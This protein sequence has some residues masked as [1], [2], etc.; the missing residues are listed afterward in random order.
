MDF[1]KKILRCAAAHLSQDE[2][3]ESLAVSDKFLPGSEIGKISREGDSWLAEVFVPKTASPPFPPNDHVNDAENPKPPPSDEED[4]KTDSDPD[5][6][7][8]ESKED[9]SPDLSDSGEDKGLKHDKGGKEDEIISLLHH[10]IESIGGGLGGPPGPPPGPPS[11]PPGLGGPPGGG[12]PPGVGGPPGGPPGIGGAPPNKIQEVIHRRGLRPGE[13]PPG[14]A[15]VGS[16][17]F[18]SFDPSVLRDL[19]TFDAVAQGHGVSIKVAQAD[20]NAR[21]FPLGFTVRSAK[22]LEDGLIVAQLSR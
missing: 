10:L 17:A 12:P 4:K 6:P 19:N 20:L 16:P 11:G 7:E 3:R 13:A 18:S 21:Y 9:S 8:P 5:E 2:V 14:V 1:E 15:P 22:R